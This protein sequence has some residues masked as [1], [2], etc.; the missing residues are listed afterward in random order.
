MHTDAREQERADARPVATATKV[1][2]AKRITPWQQKE[3]DELEARIG[4]AE[5]EQAELDARL[6]DPA[7]YAAPRA[8]LERVRARRAEL[9]A[10]IAQLYAR[11][12]VLEALR[13]TTD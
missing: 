6:A 5:G 10:E 1:T 7:L 8:E 13:S 12:E 9:Q 2:K 3:L 4:V 11:W